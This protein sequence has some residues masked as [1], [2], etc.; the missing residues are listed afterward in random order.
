MSDEKYN[1]AIAARRKML[2]EGAGPSPIPDALRKL[3]AMRGDSDKELSHSRGLAALKAASAMVQGRGLVR[4]LAQAGGAFGES[5]GQ[6][7]QA[8]KAQKR[9]LMNMEINLADAQRKERMGLNRDAIAAADQAR[10]DHDAAQQFGI[11]KATALANVAGKFATATKPT[12]AA[13]SGAG[14]EP[15]T[16]EQ[17]AAAEVAFENDPSE[18]NLKR[19]TALRR[20]VDR[21]RTSD[22]GP[23]RAGAEGAKTARQVID[24][25]RKAVDNYRLLYG[26]AFNK[27]VKDQYGGDVNAAREALI[28]LEVERAGSAANL[29]TASKGNQKPT[30][31][32]PTGAPVNNNSPRAGQNDYSN[33]WN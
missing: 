3:E 14:K 28:D 27:M 25:A 33:L 30:P 10:K 29:F 24:D 1:Q 9:A 26:S 21:I 19:V 16:N 7:L 4:G 31:A 32:K 13:G 22:V 5:Y 17:L 20:T 12:K 11:R 15:K 8:D 18:A 6:A 2:E 23:S